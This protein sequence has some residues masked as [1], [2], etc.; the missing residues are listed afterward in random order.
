MRW[1]KITGLI[2]LVAVLVAACGT[3]QDSAQMVASGSVIPFEGESTW[4]YLATWNG[5]AGL[6][7]EACELVGE[8]DRSATGWIHWVFSTKGGSTDAELRLGGS[9]SGEY[10]PGDPL[11][12]N[13][14]HFYTPFFELER[15]EATIYL[16]GGW[17]WPSRLVISDWCA[18]KGDSLRITKTAKPSFTRTHAWKVEKSVDPDS[19]YLYVDGY[20][21]H[22]A[23]TDDTVTWMVAGSYPGFDDSAFALAGT[24][25]I[26][27]VGLA[28]KTIRR[29]HGPSISTRPPPSCMPAWTWSM[30][31]VSSG[32]ARSAR[33]SRPTVRPSRTTR[34]SPGAM[35]AGT[36]AVSTRTT[37]P[38]RCWATT[39]S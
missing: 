36:R 8:A 3:V 21:P 14:W 18:G 33:S 22:D 30:Q 16:Q 34:S 29:R 11:T 24:I 19:V 31:A 5:R 9:G 32:R 37:T 38:S 39:L 23:S 2:A 35:T 25:T 6:D 17:G 28:A 10:T 26:E 1:S 12:A 20:L 7:S 13:A 15:L 27:N 4:D